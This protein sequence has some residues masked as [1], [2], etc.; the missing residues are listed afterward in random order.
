MATIARTLFVA[1]SAALGLALMGQAAP[2]QRPDSPPPQPHPQG[3][4][5]SLAGGLSDEALISLGSAVASR[6]EAV[7][8]LDSRPLKPYLKHFLGELKPK[9]VVAVGKFGEDRAALSKRL[10][11]EVEEVI[12]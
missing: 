11:V 5:V 4:V 2:V 1:L 10:G 12:P 8:L 9:R 7:L 6:P 3:R